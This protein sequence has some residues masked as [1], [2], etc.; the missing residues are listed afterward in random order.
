MTGHP[1][2]AVPPSTAGVVA[3]AVFTTCVI[4]LGVALGQVTTAELSAG[5]VRGTAVLAVGTVA[6]FLLGAV[7]VALFVRD[8]LVVPMLVVATLL[9][10]FDFV[11]ADTPGVPLF[12]AL[13]PV[14]LAGVC[15]GAG[16]EYL[17][18]RVFAGVV[19][20]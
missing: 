10:R 6:V 15:V 9:V 1:L 11:N 2:D 7:P 3:G 16:V 18:R 5:S 17:L 4:G 8:R 19:A 14:F 20:V 12:V 13:A